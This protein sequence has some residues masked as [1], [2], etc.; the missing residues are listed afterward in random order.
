MCRYM[1]FTVTGA[2]SE[3]VPAGRSTS[4]IQAAMSAVQ[5]SGTILWTVTVT[6]V[7]PVSTSVTS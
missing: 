6:P 4:M 7:G 1:I 5:T 3:A 2:V